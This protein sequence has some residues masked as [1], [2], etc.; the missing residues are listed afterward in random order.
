MASSAFLIFIDVWTV[1]M[2][3]VAYFTVIIIIIFNY[4]FLMSLHYITLK[5]I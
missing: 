2:L 1:I 4:H 5:V 3:D